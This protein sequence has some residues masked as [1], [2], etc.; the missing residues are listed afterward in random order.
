MRRTLALVVVTAS[1]LG[2]PKLFEPLWSLVSSLWSGS[3]AEVGCGLDPWGGCRPAPQPDEGCGF[4][5][6]GCPKGS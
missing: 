1:L 6:W 5:P 2:P 4:D 3:T